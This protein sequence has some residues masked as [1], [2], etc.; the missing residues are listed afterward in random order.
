[1]TDTQNKEINYES[2]IYLLKRIAKECV[3]IHWRTFAISIA[4]MVVIAATTSFHAW[5]IKPALDKV[6]VEGNKF[7]LVWIPVTVLLVT[8]VKG[9]ATYFQLFTMNVL[10]M[11]ITADLRKQLYAC[12]IKSDIAKLHNRSSGQMSASISGEINAMVGLISTLLN[13]AIK[14]TMTLVAL[15][16]VMFYQSVELSLVAFIGFPLAAY[17]IYKIGKRLRN[18]SCKNQEIAG[19]FS[20]QMHDTLQ[21]SKLVKSYNCEEFEIKRMSKIIDSVFDMGKKIS[22]LSLIASPFVESLAGIGVAAVIWY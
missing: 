15:I 12:F 16:G 18:M 22:R 14:Q 20:S 8:V 2:T 7:W 19:K 3:A 17:P 13:G 10:T 11:K 1:M 4:L 9:F 5:L 21:Y 6:F